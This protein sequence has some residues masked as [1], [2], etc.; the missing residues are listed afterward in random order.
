MTNEI[1]LNGLKDCRKS[2]DLL[3]QYS[4]RSM[5]L[6]IF[7]P[8]FLAV[9]FFLLVFSP[10]SLTAQRHEVRN[11]SFTVTQQ[12]LIIV[13]YDL[14]GADKNYMVEL[15]LKRKSSR[16]YSVEPQTM[17][18]DVGKGKFSGTGN[19]II[20]S[21]V[22]DMGEDF[23]LDPYVDDYYFIVRARKRTRG[24]GLWLSAIA[25]ATILYFIQ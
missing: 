20:W 11:V 5:S 6:N 13:D 1:S 8:R 17:M 12:N 18:G 23:L 7:P 3:C 22:N 21:P 16:V 24:T 25:A 19:R 9:F 14:I 15:V 10:F 4:K 2:K